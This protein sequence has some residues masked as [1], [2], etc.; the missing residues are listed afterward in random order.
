MFHPASM[1]RGAIESVTRTWGTGSTPPARARAARHKAARKRELFLAEKILANAENT[2][3]KIVQSGA[4][5]TP[6]NRRRYFMTSPLGNDAGAITPR[7][8]LFMESRRLLALLAPW[9]L[10]VHI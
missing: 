10:E 5:E 1:P 4:A 3:M 7:D 2:R 6:A 8:N 9:T